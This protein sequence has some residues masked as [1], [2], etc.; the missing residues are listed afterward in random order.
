MQAAQHRSVSSTVHLH[1]RCHHGLCS[2]WSHSKHHMH[3]AQGYQFPTLLSIH[4]TNKESFP[5][6]AHGPLLSVTWQPGWEGVWGRTDM[7]ICMAE[8]LHCLLTLL[9]GYAP[10]QNKKL[11]K[12]NSPFL[13]DPWLM[14]TQWRRHMLGI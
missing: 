8:S 7:Y 11:K 1:P 14:T 6:R 3:E 10:I 4:P 5:T 13:L 2:K 12:E 9:T